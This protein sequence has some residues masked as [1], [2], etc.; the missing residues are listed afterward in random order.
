MSLFPTIRSRLRGGLLA[1]EARRFSLRYSIC[2]TKEEDLFFRFAGWHRASKRDERFDERRLERESGH[3]AFGSQPLERALN[4]I[5]SREMFESQL[6][7]MHS[8]EDSSVRTRIESL[9]KAVARLE[10]A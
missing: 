2:L 7:S 5:E 9:E 8:E 6:E 1:L 4:L 10:D 3:I